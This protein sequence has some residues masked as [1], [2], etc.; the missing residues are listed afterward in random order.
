MF[1]P[2]SITD[3]RQQMKYLRSIQTIHATKERYC[4]FHELLIYILLVRHVRDTA[5]EEKSLI[6]YNHLCLVK[7][8]IE[9]TC[10]IL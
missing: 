1:L 2:P 4:L 10:Y 5:R 3:I 9:D 6:H 8:G 7:H